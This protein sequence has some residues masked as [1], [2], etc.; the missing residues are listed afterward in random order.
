[1]QT[2]IPPGF[3]TDKL[4]AKISGTL[5]S[6]AEKTSPYAFQWETHSS[7]GSSES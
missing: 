3:G 4:Y 5:H 6:R 2:N 7:F 1:M